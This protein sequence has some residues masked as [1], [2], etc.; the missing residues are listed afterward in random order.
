LRRGAFFLRGAFSGFQSGASITSNSAI[1]GGLSTA[2]ST[3]VLGLV[4]AIPAL[5]A[6]NYLKTTV[7]KLTSDMEDF[8]H[9]LLSTLELQYR[10]ID[11]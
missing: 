1:L 3:T 5:I 6:H 8:L 4:I 9:T 2:L 11:L 7:N 10:K